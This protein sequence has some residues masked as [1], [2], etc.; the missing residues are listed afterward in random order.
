MVELSDTCWKEKFP[1]AP[2]QLKASILAPK[3][4]ETD[5]KTDG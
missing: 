5:K 2:E 3:L 1:C 4:K